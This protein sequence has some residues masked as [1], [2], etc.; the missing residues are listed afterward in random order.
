MGRSKYVCV[1][2]SVNCTTNCEWNDTDS[3]YLRTSV[4]WL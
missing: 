1:C 2:V 4:A 3:G